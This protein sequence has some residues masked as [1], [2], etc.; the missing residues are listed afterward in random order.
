MNYAVQISAEQAG[1]TLAHAVRALMPP[2]CSWA[3]ARELCKRGKVR[4]NG[5][6]IN[7]AALRLSA[8]DAVEV[9][10]H[11]KRMRENDLDASAIVYADAQL[12]VVNKPSGL[13]SVPFDNADKDTLIDRV[14]THLRRQSG[15]EGTELGAVQ[16]LDKDTTGLLVFA[17]TLPVKRQLQQLFRDHTIERRY[18]AL[19]HGAVS[20]QSFETDLIPDRGDGL[21]GS[22][23][24]FRRPRGGLPREAQHAVTHVRPLEALGSA[25]LLE[26][27]LETGRQHQIRIHLSEAGHPL[28]GEPVYVRDYRQPLMAA[29]RPMLHAA[30]LGFVH[31]RTHELLHFESAP[32]EDFASLLASL[33]ALSR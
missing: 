4:V 16:R 14:R 30:V 1:C 5:K 10:P 17:R 32:P 8:G 27:K 19:A 31:P 24:H 15:G 26:C 13:L 25:T 21:R 20:E 22:F 3:Q 9:D 23:G 33:R 11:A 7:D 18:L 2:P 12:V 29:A 28:L 6:I